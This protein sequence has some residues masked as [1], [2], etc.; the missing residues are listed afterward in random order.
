MST[1]R[2]NQINHELQQALITVRETCTKVLPL[3]EELEDLGVRLPP[4]T[5][6]MFLSLTK[7]S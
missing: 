2:I 5:R 3:I 7:M 6:K 1:E 4:E